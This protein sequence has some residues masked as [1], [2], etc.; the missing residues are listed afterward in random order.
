[1]F[2]IFRTDLIS[3]MKL[4]DSQIL[5]T[6]NYMSITDTWRQEWERGV[7]VSSS[8]TRGEGCIPPKFLK[9]DE[10]K[11]SR[12]QCIYDLNRTDVE[13]LTAL[14]S[15]TLS[16]LGKTEL[17]EGT[18]EKAIA[19][20]EDKCYENMGYAIVTQKGLSIEYDESVCCDVCQ[21]PESE[22]GNEMVFCDSCDICVH[23]ACYGIQ[24][25]PSGSWLCQPCRWGVAKPPCKLCSACGG[26][27]KKAKGGK[28]YIHVSCALW[29]PE[30]GFGNVERMEP[31]IKVEKIPTSRWNLVCYLCKEKVGA[32]IQ[33]S[34]KS[35]VTAFHV[36][37]GFQEGLDMRTILDDTEVDGVR[38][39]SYCSKHG[40]KNKSPGKSPGRPPKSPRKSPNKS[41]P[42]SPEKIK[43]DK[44][45]A[46]NQRQKRLKQMEGEFYNYVDV[47]EIAKDLALPKEL[48]SHIHA[49]WTLKRKAR[50]DVPLVPPT[51]QQ[52]EKLS[53][54]QGAADISKNLQVQIER[55]MKMRCDLERLRNLC[56]MVGK[57]EKMRRELFRVR[58]R[59]F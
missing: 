12:T 3:A 11:K 10:K 7:Q 43:Q 20:M 1:M 32:C 24:S 26:A 48:A 34:V 19:Y 55:L 21:S 36:T 37:C 30:V 50:D 31:I 51:P 41:P 59:V 54:K 40:Y 27:M 4:P 52:Q 58:E 25:I 9:A 8:Q 16:C 14:N 18:L 42:R 35:C 29:V 46:E 33:C 22:E 49:Y 15:I 47:G 57:R 17:D 45:E 2:Q 5:N 56:Y 23:Q 53:G 39:V 6:E 13:W 44:E 38:H 28:T